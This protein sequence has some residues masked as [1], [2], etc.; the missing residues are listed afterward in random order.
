MIVCEKDFSDGETEVVFSGAME[1]ALVFAAGEHD[2]P[3]A[4]CLADQKL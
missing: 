4:G 3:G 1:A 2:K